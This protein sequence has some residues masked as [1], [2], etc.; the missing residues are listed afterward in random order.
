MRKCS[1]CG[2]ELT[3]EVQFCP[4]CGSKQ[5]NR[6]NYK[7]SVEVRFCTGC[8]RRW[9]EDDQFC[10]VCGKKY[11]EDPLAE[12][13]AEATAEAAEK[14]SGKVRKP[15]GTGTGAIGG[16]LGDKVLNSNLLK[17]LGIVFCAIY[18][19]NALTHLGY[20]ASDYGTFKFLGVVL[21]VIYAWCSA[22][23]FA[24]AY[25]CKQEYSSTLFLALAGGEILRGIFAI[26][27]IYQIKEYQSWNTSIMTYWPLIDS[28]VVV[29]GGFYLMKYEGM[30]EMQEGWLLQDYLKDIPIMLKKVFPKKGTI[31][32]EAWKK[33]QEI[34]V[35]PKTEKEK[36]LF[37][38]KDNI[39]LA[40]G[41]LYT[42]KVAYNV[43][44]SFSFL[45]LVTGIFPILTCVAIW[46]VYSSGRKGMLTSSGFTISGVIAWIKVV[47]HGLI[48]FILM[49]VAGKVN[50][51]LCLAVLA[52]AVLDVYYW[53]CIAN[54]L[55]T[56][57]KNVMGQT[58]EIKVG[59]YPIVILILNVI[60]QVPG[61]ILAG[62]M[63]F[64]S[65]I[66]NSLYQF[67]YSNFGGIYDMLGRDAFN[68]AISMLEKALG[69][70]SNVLMALVMV[71][72]PVL[73]ILLLRKIRAYKSEEFSD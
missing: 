16:A 42:V 17:I 59:M 43:L 32:A 54:V 19:Y 10:P 67:E 20:L 41:V 23:C 70:N 9:K 71:A 60:K 53:W 49:A 4:Y 72:I 24:V 55:W 15:M 37:I 14:A 1:N 29:V 46:L 2:K 13:A 40:F 35:Q 28:I 39:F 7:D 26:M 36:I 56:M 63:A 44:G 50:A 6:E 33:D 31:E 66:L 69:I 47:G 73:E 30:L 34:L 38:V 5:E 25:R 3:E 22:M 52:I 62:T 12:A 58:A 57:R 8:G 51:G 61:L 64:G 18:A 68:M 27:E 45:K 65:S 11:V 48:G 21:T